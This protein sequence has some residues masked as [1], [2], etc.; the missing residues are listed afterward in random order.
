M[1]LMEPVITRKARAILLRRIEYGDH[2]VVLTFLTAE[3]GKVS[4]FAKNAKKS[5]KRFSGVLELFT[6]LEVVIRQGRGL[7]YLDEASIESPFESIR[8]DYL[9]MAYAGYWSEITVQWLEEGVPQKRLF[10]LFKTA[11]DALHDARR[12]PGTVSVL[13]QLLFLDIAGFAPTLWVCSGCGKG[14]E[15]LPRRK[16]SFDLER[17]GLVCE[18]CRKECTQ[19]VALAAGTVMKLRWIME[20]GLSKA[21]RVKFSPAAEAE[22]LTLLEHFLPRHL[23]R[24]PRSLGFLGEIRRSRG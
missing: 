23:G 11:L 5:I 18:T 17:G 9:R 8:T 2:D 21:F 6:L 14:M 1:A 22:A 20:Q 19:R 4:A 24:E 10:T 13:F 16:V 12:S 3:E 15:K 7:P